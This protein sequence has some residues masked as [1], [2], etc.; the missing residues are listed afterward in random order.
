MDNQV[1]GASAKSRAKQYH[2]I[3][4]LLFFADLGV[5]LLLLGW[6]QLS[7]SSLSLK[8]WVSSF[9]C[10]KPIE[11]ALYLL[12]FFGLLTFALL[13]IRFYSGFLLE[14]NF[15][16]SNQKAH[17]WIWD[18]IKKTLLSL[19]F[20]MATTELLFFIVDHFPKSWWVLASVGWLFLTLFLAR[21]LPTVLI[22]IFYRT[23]LLTDASLKERLICL[24][25]KCRVKVLSVYEI[26]LSKKT[27]KANAALTGLGKSRRILLADTLRERYSPSEIE[28]VVAHELGHHVKK[29]ILKSFFLGFLI[30]VTGF[31]LL[32]T[33]SSQIIRYLHAES[34]TDL[35]I[36]P[37]LVLL[38]T[39]SG[40]LILPFQNSL[41][42]FFEY[43]ADRYAWETMRS[44]EVFISLMNKLGEQNL[45]D[46]EPHPFIEFFFYDHP[47]IRNRIKHICALSTALPV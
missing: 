9:S 2:R 6:L 22:P 10:P 19:T 32:S 34:L 37:A 13:P 17:D 24:C 28:M 33:V 39:L 12:I 47:S 27:K 26:A 29:H 38:S 3:K 40:F 23:K 36:F 18:E 4:Y 5:S 1:L 8:G 43:E 25:Q 35:S 20:F 42:R 31:Y 45:A 16:L 21:I 15:D 30:T 11:I 14:R 44:N 46:S 7:G 41:S